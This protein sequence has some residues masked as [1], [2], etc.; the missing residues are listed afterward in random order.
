MKAG[1]CSLFSY[2]DKRLFRK[3]C[4]KERLENTIKDV[5]II[6]NRIRKLNHSY[7]SI[8]EE[9]IEKELETCYCDLELSMALVAVIIRKLV[10]NQFTKISDEDRQDIN[11]LVHSNRFDYMGDE[12][13][14][15]SRLSSEDVQ[16]EHFIE[17]GKSILDQLK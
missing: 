5:E 11:A 9:I 14:V 17:L 2:M 10:E 6:V 4:Y 7:E 1:T 8:N 12:V 13:I 15:F 3:N 16:I